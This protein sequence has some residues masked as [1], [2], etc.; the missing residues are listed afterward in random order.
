[1]RSN[2]SRGFHF[3]FRVVLTVACAAAATLR[4]AVGR[5]MRMPIG[6][7]S[8]GRIGTISIHG[9]TCSQGRLV[10]SQFHSPR[11]TFPAAES[12]IDRG[13]LVA[14]MHHAIGAFGVSRSMT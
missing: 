11:K 4:M 3:F 6:T 7:V 9:L 14:A 10:E 2:L 13:R 8:V 5:S 12:V 1:M